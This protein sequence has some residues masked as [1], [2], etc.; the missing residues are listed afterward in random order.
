MKYQRKPE[1]V[2]AEQWFPDKPIDNVM[3][4][5]FHVTGVL[6]D[7]SYS[8]NHCGLLSTPDGDRVWKGRS[9]EPNIEDIPHERYYVV[10]SG[11]WIVTDERGRIKVCKNDVFKQ[12]YEQCPKNKSNR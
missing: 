7:D 5:A 8:M 4:P 12:R 10:E 2:E 1:I 9:W 3:F 11:D 6:Q